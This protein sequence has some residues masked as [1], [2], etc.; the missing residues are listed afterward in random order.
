MPKKSSKPKN[1][2]VSV[3]ASIQPAIAELERAFRALAVRFPVLRGRPY[4]RIVIQSRGRKR[5]VL[6]WF[7]RERWRDGNEN[8]PPIHEIAII[9]EALSLPVLLIVA[10][11]VHE[12]VHLA[13][14]YVGIQD[15]GKDG[16][17][18][19]QRFR[20]AAEAV[21]LLVKK[22]MRLGWALTSLGPELEEF[23]SSLNINADAFSI[24]RLGEPE[25]G[26]QETKNKKWICGCNNIRAATKIKPHCLLC[27]NV[28]VRADAGE[29]PYPYQPMTQ[30]SADTNTADEIMM[31]AAELIKVGD[32]Q[33]ALRKLIMAL[34]ERGKFT[35]Q[36]A[37][38]FKELQ[39]TK[40]EANLN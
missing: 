27:G 7:A 2:K 19:N 13:C 18:H 38:R 8:A 12:M 16:R 34:F 1:I 35:E 6:G 23:V 28:Y 32:P 10:I 14:Y 33:E 30:Q 20:E 5:Y 31:S 29:K 39:R 11:L 9:A 4:P 25:R 40:E 15:I 37:Q 17:Y 26:K 24:F 21:G 3:N 22:D 36:D